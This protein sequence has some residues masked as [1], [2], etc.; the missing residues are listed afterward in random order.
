MKNLHANPITPQLSNFGWNSDKNSFQNLFST[1][2]IPLE[3]TKKIILSS[4]PQEVS[5]IM[6]INHAWFYLIRSNNLIYTSK[7]II[8]HCINYSKEISENITDTVC[9]TDILI[10]I[11]KLDPQGHLLIAKKSAKNLP[12]KMDRAKALIKIGEVDPD[13][14][15]TLAKLVTNQI[16]FP[17]FQSQLYCRISK[18]ESLNNLVHAEDTAKCIK[19]AF[20]RFKAFL[21]ISKIGQYQDLSL[22]LKA[23]E[24]IGDSTQLFE[25]IN[26]LLKIDIL[27]DSLKIKLTEK[28]KILIEGH[29]VQTN[30]FV[31]TDEIKLNLHGQLHHKI[32]LIN[33]QR[34]LNPIIQEIMRISAPFS[35]VKALLKLAEAAIK[36]MK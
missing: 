14:D 29:K 34:D 12:E 31:W 16:E 35:R 18:F 13:H 4:Q 20:G 23:F 28:R 6:R 19:S 3:I 32:T 33:P 21:Y 36:W 17:P 27:E 9:K 15:F 2:E 7:I 5:E 24:E 1:Y 8:P 25:A 26:K 11:A 10:K 22:T 30:S